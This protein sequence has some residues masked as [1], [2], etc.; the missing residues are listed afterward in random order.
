MKVAIKKGKRA[1][2]INQPITKILVLSNG[3][4][5]VEINGKMAFLNFNPKNE[6]LLIWDDV[7]GKE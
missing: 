5:A 6:Q 3:K 7:K 1:E 4:F 2:L